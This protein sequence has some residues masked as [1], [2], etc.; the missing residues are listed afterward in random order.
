MKRLFLAGV[1]ALCIIFALTA[2]SGKTAQSTDLPSEDAPKTAPSSEPLPEEEDPESA[3]L[4]VE[5]DPSDSDYAVIETQEI[6]AGYPSDML[7]LSDDNSDKI[8]TIY[9]D[10]EGTLFDFKIVTTRSAKEVVEEYAAMWELEDEGTV[11]MDDKGS[12]TLFGSYQGYGV[13]VTGSE[14]SPYLPEG[15]KTFVAIL[16]EKTE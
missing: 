6:P 14:E 12:A 16:V 13:I 7:P 9:T 5:E 15:A 4:P 11:I 2:C 3:G 8:I 1:I 10:E